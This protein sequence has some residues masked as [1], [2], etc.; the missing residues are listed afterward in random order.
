MDHV[1][2]LKL[3]P[4]VSCVESPTEKLAWFASTT[5]SPLL[6]KIPCHLKHLHAHLEELRQLEPNQ[7]KGY[8]FY[9]ADVTALY[10][11]ID[12][13]K[14]IDDII[15]LAGE[16][17]SELKTYDILKSDLKRILETIFLNSYF[18]FDGI[19]YKQIQGL[20]MGCMPSPFGAIVR[21]YKFERNSIYID[22]A[23]ITNIFYGRYVDNAGSVAKSEESTHQIMKMIADQDPDKLLKWEIDFLENPDEYTP[24]LDTEV[25]IDSEDNLYTRFYRKVFM[26]NIVL[27]H[28][29]QLKLNMK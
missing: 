13:P 1:G 6:N 12:I 28:T 20:F 9:S 8:S 26:K 23:Y 19:L 27:D 29:I 14:C 25:S 21:V 7:L 11:N 22:I 2:D 4:I 15:E 16:Y 3:R 5:L 17:W 24:S 10:T 18:I